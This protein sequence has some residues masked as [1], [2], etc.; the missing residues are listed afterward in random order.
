MVV[1]VVGEIAEMMG[2]SI[3]I[4]LGV[5]AITFVA[6]GT[7]LP[8]TFASKIAAQESKYADSAIGNITGS[9]AVNVF[10]GL[11]LPWTISA[12]YCSSLEIPYTIEAEGLTFSV[13]LYLCC[14][15]VCIITLIIR[16]CVVKGE[17]GGSNGGRWATFIFFV[18]M[19]V[20][21]VT[22]SACDQYGLID[23]F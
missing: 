13:I 22:L 2:C 5:T 18:G 17:L 3:G 11:G 4:K 14:S 23:T 19:W 12:A 1:V 21:Y 15:T 6:I 20:L 9:N 7:S 8:D 10:L 16:R